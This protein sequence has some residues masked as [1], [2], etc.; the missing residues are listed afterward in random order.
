VPTV[1]VREQL[2]V[3]PSDA[4][5]TVTDV[6]AYP[7]RMPSV[8][9]VRLL[10]DPGEGFRRAAWSVLLRGSVLRWVE[11]EYL[12]PEAR[13]VRF[14]QESGDLDLFSGHWAV[15]PHGDG[16]LVTLHVDFDIGIPLLADML[17][18]IARTA[19]ADN[20]VLMLRALEHAQAGAQA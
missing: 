5:A 2:S 13:I 11:R 16:S 18:P 6:E 19:L 10:D 14:E 3:A 12:D 9:S 15:Q 1:E 20:A 4:W 7:S 17:N 8:Q